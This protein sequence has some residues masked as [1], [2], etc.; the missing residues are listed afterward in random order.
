MKQYTQEELKNLYDSVD[1]MWD[2]QPD[3]AYNLASIFTEETANKDNFFVNSIGFWE[4]RKSRPRRKPDHV[5]ANKSAA[6]RKGKA[7]VSSEYWYTEDGVIRGSDHWG[8]DVASCSWYFKGQKTA[9]DGV[10]KTGK[11]YAFIPWSDLKAKGMIGRNHETGEYSLI[12][13]TFEK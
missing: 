3:E 10:R 2:M 7:E 9:K 4:V 6:W 8:K 11:T 12:G 13:F 1:M 5:S